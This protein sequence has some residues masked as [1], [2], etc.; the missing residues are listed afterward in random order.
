MGCCKVKSQAVGVTISTLILRVVFFRQTLHLSTSRKK[1]RRQREQTTDGKTE[2]SKK[3]AYRKASLG[4]ASLYAIFH[5][6]R[7]VDI[8]PHIL[9]QPENCAPSRNADC[10]LP[11]DVA[12]TV[13]QHLFNIRLKIED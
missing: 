1:S 7:L 4:I 2:K 13:K 8:L 10:P 12:V 5:F 3:T 6:H 9:G 11:V